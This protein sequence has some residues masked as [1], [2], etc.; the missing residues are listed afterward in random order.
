MKLKYFA[1]AIILTG[2]ASSP[3]STV[4][5]VAL[6]TVKD[7]I[8]ECVPGHEGALSNGIVTVRPGETVCIRLEVAGSSVT[9]AEVVSTNVEGSTLVLRAWSEPGSNFTFLSIHN[10]LD[11]LLRYEAYLISGRKDSPEYTSS[12]PV[13]SHRLGIEHWP[14]AV[15]EFT[16]AGFRTI[17]ETEGIECK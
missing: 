16:L 4:E 17:P 1:L 2:C 12:C 11:A 10:P 7:P 3:P 8:P 5:R 14:Y 13:L 15:T 6:E 9:P